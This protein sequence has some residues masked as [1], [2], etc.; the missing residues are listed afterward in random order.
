MGEENGSLQSLDWN[1]WT[2]NGGPEQWNCRFA[3]LGVKGLMCRTS[4]HGFRRA[5]DGPSMQTLD[6]L[7]GPPDSSKLVLVLRGQTH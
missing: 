3:V 2:G 7:N 1:E 6:G 5:P 4:V